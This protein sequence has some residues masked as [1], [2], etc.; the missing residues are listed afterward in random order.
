MLATTASLQADQAALAGD[1]VHLGSWGPDPVHGEVRV[2][3][4]TPGSNDFDA[5]GT[6]LATSLGSVTAADDRRALR[7]DLPNLV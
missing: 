3:L 2:Q 7:T 6:A 1:G 5:L 4:T